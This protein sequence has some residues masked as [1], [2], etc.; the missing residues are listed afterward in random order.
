MNLSCEIEKPCAAELFVET[1]AAPSRCV[2]VRKRRER[3]E[4]AVRFEKRTV[5]E[6][7]G[8]TETALK[9]KPSRHS[10]YLC[11]MNEGTDLQ[12]S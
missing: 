4:K 7:F 6:N 1:A 2:V 8:K 11:S 10:R 9:S 5:L 12:P 3:G